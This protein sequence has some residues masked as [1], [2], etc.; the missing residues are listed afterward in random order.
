MIAK[1]VPWFIGVCALALGWSAGP[2]NAA[3]VK[4][5]E[6]DKLAT[7][8]PGLVGKTIRIGQDGVSAPFSYTDP[9]DPE[10]LLGADA[11]Y[12]RAVFACIG[13]PVEFS[14]GTW[15][16][17]LPA[18]AAGR[19][20]IM[21]DDLYYTPERAKMV[22]YVLYS[23]AT[24]AAV[25]HKGNPKKL[26]SLTDLCGLRGVAGLGTIEIV[27]MTD[28]SK[29]CVDDGKPPVDITTYSSRPAAWQMIDTDRADIVMSSQ[30]MGEAAAKDKPDTLEVGFTFLTQIKV[31]AAVAK[32]R[33]EL[34]QA[35]SDAIA[36][37]QASGQI[38]KIFTTY[39][40]D[41]NLLIPPQILTQ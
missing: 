3:D 9:N 18:V 30:A 23:A 5:C 6:P 35:M 34:E 16:G 27:M 21:W 26:K 40:I 1:S 11:D 37:T 15:S 41:P 17:L 4:P 25:V 10:H 2:A 31:G 36:A 14:V 33:T 39:K 19:I 22:D 12:A 29:K 7:R 24:D 28:I 38:A 20:D 13:V 32:G 8:Y